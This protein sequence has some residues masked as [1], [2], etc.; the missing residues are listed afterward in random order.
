MKYF[1]SLI[2]IIFGFALYYILAGQ[3]ESVVSVPIRYQSAELLPLAP[4]VEIGE[5]YVTALT[6]LDS[7]DQI[8]TS[9]TGRALVKNGPQLLTSIGENSNVNFLAA[10]EL[11]QTTFEVITGQLWSRLERALEQDE[12]YKVHTPTLAAAVRGTSFGAEV[13]NAIDRIIV[14]AG[15]VEVSDRSG[16]SS[17]KVTAGNMVRLVDG[18]LAVTPFSEADFDEWMKEPTDPNWPLGGAPEITLVTAHREGFLWSN[19]GL[20]TVVGTGF[21]QVMRLEIDGKPVRFVPVSDTIFRIPII[22]LT[23][24]REDS[25]AYLYYVGGSISARDIFVGSEEEVRAN[26]LW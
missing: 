19:P 9:N 16:T 23:S 4:D 6:K 21:N 1:F 3:A 15:V 14:F 5:R 12:V 10:N 13:S 24:V 17:E 7:G 26:M 22:E 25:E 8:T 18:R 2:L 20:I 11:A